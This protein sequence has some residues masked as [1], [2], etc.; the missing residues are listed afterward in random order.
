MTFLHNAE[1]L[2]K[3]VVCDDWQPK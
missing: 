3:M 2:E 1:L